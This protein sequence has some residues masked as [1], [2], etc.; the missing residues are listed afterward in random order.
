MNLYFFIFKAHINLKSSMIIKVLECSILVGNFK[1]YISVNNLIID[2]FVHPF[3][4]KK[5]MASQD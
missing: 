4:Y 2:S 1:L 3:T 5:L